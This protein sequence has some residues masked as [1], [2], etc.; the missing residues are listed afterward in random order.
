MKDTNMLTAGLVIGEKE[1]FSPPPPHPNSVVKF[2][3]NMR[4]FSGYGGN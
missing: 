3:P 2:P 4:L 1:G